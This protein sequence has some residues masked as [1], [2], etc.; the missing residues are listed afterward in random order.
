MKDH[1]ILPEL[2]PMLRT[3][4]KSIGWSLV[5]GLAASA[6]TA[7]AEFAYDLRTFF[8][9]GIWL[10]SLGLPVEWLGI[11]RSSDATSFLDLH[12]LF[13]SRGFL[14]N[15]L[16]W[17]AI[18][19]V[20]IFLLRVLRGEFPALLLPA[21]VVALGFARILLEYEMAVAAFGSIVGFAWIDPFSYAHIVTYFT[22]ALLLFPAVVVLVSRL[23]FRE[24]FRL[25]CLGLPIILM[26]PILDNYVLHRPVIYNFY[27]P[28]LFPQPLNPL[29]YL[30]VVSTG[31]KLEALVVASA[32]FTYLLYR[33]RSIPRS[34]AAVLAVVLAFV[35]VT[36][37]I[38]TDQFHLMFSQPQF[39]AGFLILTYL[40]IIGDL[41]LAQPKIGTTII[42]RMRL[43]GAH[44]PAMVVFGAFLLQPAILSLGILEDYGLVLAG[45]FIAF[46]IWQSATVFDDIY[47]RSE[48]QGNSVYLCY[49]LLTVVMAVL[50]AIPFGLLPLLL[51]V[52]AAYLAMHY[53]RLRRRHYVF[54]GL[55]IGIA[56]SLSFLLGASI[57]ITGPVTRQPIGGIALALFAVFSGGS[58]VKDIATVREDK[59]SGVFTVFTKFEMRKMLPIVSTF[60]AAGCIL[61]VVFLNALPDLILFAAIG[62]GN[63]LL[64]VLMRSRSYRPVLALYFTEGLWIFYRMFLSH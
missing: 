42:R 22:M 59:Q 49:G 60:V 6:L 53:A 41:G 47:D 30:T 20:V 15:L 44:F 26:P 10:K 9:Q 61:P 32:A 40:L 45:A 27:T 51:T 58:L 7:F 54:S 24:I 64:I 14:Q 23:P 62:C 57:P 55:V 5:L 56:S 38:V 1:E 2:L 12:F 36:T 46:L 34:F 48:M 28:G 4:V 18:L 3:N 52:F 63:W 17:A 19:F 50:A 13:F 16:F 37:P 8:S 39:F 35:A 25:S 21:Y 31:I 33:T 29:S 11:L 43:R